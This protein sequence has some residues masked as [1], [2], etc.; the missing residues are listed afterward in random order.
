MT[1]EVDQTELVD[2]ELVLWRVFGLTEVFRDRP[3]PF[4]SVEEVRGPGRTDHLTFFVGD[5]PENLVSMARQWRAQTSMLLDLLIGNV[6]SPHDRQARYEQELDVVILHEFEKPYANWFTAR[7]SR[8]L[9]VEGRVGRVTG[10]LAGDIESALAKLTAFEGEGNAYLDGA[11]AHLL[12]PMQG[13]RLGQ[14]RFQGSAY[15]AAPGRAA[16]RYP[17]LHASVDGSGVRVERAE[18][19]AT[20]PTGEITNAIRSLPSGRGFN[21]MVS[22]PSRWLMAALAEEDEMRRFVLAFAGIELLATQAERTVRSRLIDRIER[23]DPRLPVDQLLYPATDKDRVW[24]NLVFRFA[25]MASVY[26]P[27]TAVADVE[28]FRGL[29]AAR[30]NLFHGSDERAMQNSSIQCR[31]LLRRYLALVACDAS[32]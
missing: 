14:L 16:L 24:R 19:W 13:M 28:V 2:A 8:P 20:T 6:I 12:A 18:G 7:L 1:E 3:L 27:E 26:S 29:A 11:I 4:W 31:D 22:G 9:S 17:Q 21:K 30:N 15:L 32:T 25:A 5:L 23:S 10:W